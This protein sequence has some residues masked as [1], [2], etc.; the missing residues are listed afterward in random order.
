MKKIS[1]L[2]AF[3]M[4][5]VS[6]AMM[7]A[8]GDNSGGKTSDGYSTELN[9]FNWTEYMP[10]TVFD[11]FYDEYGIT[12]NTGE[13]SSNEELLA[14][15]LA[16][17]TSQWDL[18]VASNYMIPTF[19]EKDL[20]Q[21]LTKENITNFGNLDEN[22]VSLSSDPNNEYSVPYMV[23]WTLIGV[24]RDLYNKDITTFND[25]LDPE[26]KQS[27]VVPDDVREVIA[28]ALVGMG[29]D[30]NSKDEAVV[31]ATAP[32][33]KELAPNIKLFDSDSPKNA[34]IAGEVKVAYTWGAEIALAMRENP[35]IEVVFPEGVLHCI[36]SFVITKD[37]K[38]AREAE[39][40]VDFVL[41]P[42]ISAMITED[43]PYTNPNKAAQPL[44]GD[45]YM[46][47]PACNVPAEVVERANFY[48]ELGDAV[49][50][51]D[52]LWSVVKGN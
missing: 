4:A 17:A 47:N 24:N 13:F 37:A 6:L 21:P 16:G 9:F 30:P 41:R 8:C 5:L 51:W 23:S 52:E 40:F 42:E 3:A 27:V 44:L 31:K 29:E 11:A 45:E 28:M 1:R 14:K 32:W 36:D 49:A 33:L 19:V 46:N 12:V 20:I 15:L 38:H 25:L 43:Y 35:S 22:Y 10:Q 18:T 2:F 34:M 26:L 50:V 39:L 7:A 48:E